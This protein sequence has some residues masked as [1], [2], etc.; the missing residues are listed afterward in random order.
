MHEEYIYNRIK[1][2]YVDE[3]TNEKRLFLL[4]GLTKITY[5]PLNNSV[6]R[7]VIPIKTKHFDVLLSEAPKYSEL[8]PVGVVSKEI[9]KFEYEQLLSACDNDPK[10]LFCF[11]INEKPL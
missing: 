11:A 5:Q 9:T 2:I 7:R 6:R 4:A 3:D 10:V 1:D 8:I